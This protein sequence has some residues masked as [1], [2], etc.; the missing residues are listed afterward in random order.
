MTEQQSM[1]VTELLRKIEASWST[2]NAY[3]DTLTEAQLTQP[4]DAAGWTAKDHLIHIAS[5]E[6][7]L[8]ALLDKS[9]QWEHMGVD[10]ALFFSGDEINAVIQKRYQNMPLAE[11][12]QKHQE[13]H[14]NLMSKLSKLSDE[15]LY[16]PVR[17]YQPDF[18]AHTPH[19]SLPYWGYFRGLR[20]TH[21]L[22]CRH[23]RRV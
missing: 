15:D 20:G 9:P 4:T 8:N 18:S 13:I 1:T 6:D 5:W 7:T 19:P 10:K 14:K 17:D 22:D 12:R 3:I 2:F 23:R 11:V 16:R 21:A